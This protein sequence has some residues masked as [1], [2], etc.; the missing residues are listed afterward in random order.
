M[1]DHAGMKDVLDLE[2]GELLLVNKP[3]DWTSF[4]VVARIRSMYHI[5]KIGHAGTL[6]PK[7]TGLLLLCTGKMTKMIDQ[8]LGLEKE[9]EGII[10]IGAITKSFDSETE[11]IEKKEINAIR[12][13][14]IIDIFKLFIG[15]QMQLPPMYSAV[16]INGRRL[17]KDARKGRTVEREPRE[18]FIKEFELTSFE[19][20][21]VGFKVV[22]SKGTY[23]RSLANDVG[24]KLGC[25][26]Y[27]KE[28]SRTRIGEY[29][30]NDSYT[31]EQLHLLGE[32][33]SLTTAL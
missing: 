26:A 7:A 27:L 13:E 22:C 3:K 25:G 24:V 9:Y 17:Y 15:Y 6:D 16:K 33:F 8:F 14:Q 32:K 12:R 23:I 4:D 5:Q 11:V 10:E 31:V 18:I 28:L 21:F 30:V 20:P 19:P 29:S 1:I 2:A